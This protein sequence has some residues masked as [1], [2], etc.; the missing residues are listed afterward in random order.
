MDLSVFL[1]FVHWF[2]FYI[3][4]FLKVK[5]FKNQMMCFFAGLDIWDCRE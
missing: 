2:E 3:S 4:N 5:P 1:L